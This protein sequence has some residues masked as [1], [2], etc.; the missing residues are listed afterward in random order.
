MNWIVEHYTS[1]GLVGLLGACL[2]LLAYGL[3]GKTS[4]KTAAYLYVLLVLVTPLVLWAVGN[5]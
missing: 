3:T 4:L 5:K 1:A 2:L